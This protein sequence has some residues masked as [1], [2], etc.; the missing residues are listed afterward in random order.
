MAFGSL[1]Q[2]QVTGLI[3]L[4]TFLWAVGVVKI[5]YAAHFC[6]VT[7]T[8]RIGTL[9]ASIPISYGLIAA[10]EYLFA[11]P[12]TQ[13]LPM[14]TLVGTTTLVLDGLAMTWFPSLYANE[15]I[16][17]TN[18]RSAAVLSRMGAGWLLYGTGFAL[19]WAILTS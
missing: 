9:L 14:V 15:S 4:G 18:P 19:G 2:S 6:Y 3:G 7:S 11:V 8:R 17:K 10:A 12:S 16:K 1:N 5:R 13:R